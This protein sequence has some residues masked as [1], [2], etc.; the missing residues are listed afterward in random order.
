MAAPLVWHVISTSVCTLKP[1]CSVA[2]LAGV[3]PKVT[4]GGATRL[5]LKVERCDVRRAA[6]GEWRASLARSHL[7]DDKRDVVLL[8][9]FLE[10][11]EEVGRGVK[12]AA[13]TLNRLHDHRGDVALA[14]PLLVDLGAH[15]VEAIA[16]LLPIVVVVLVERVA[17]ARKIGDGPVECGNID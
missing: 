11:A 12:I 2:K 4:A 13:F 3:R 9:D 10:A 14:A 7:I 16:I 15:V 8:A 17:I 5:N 1:P 6:R